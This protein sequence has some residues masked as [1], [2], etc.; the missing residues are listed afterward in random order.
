M[1]GLDSKHAGNIFNKSTR[2]IEK[3][4]RI[5]DKFVK[6]SINRLIEN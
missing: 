4:C 1:D 3:H 2:L 5:S 6:A